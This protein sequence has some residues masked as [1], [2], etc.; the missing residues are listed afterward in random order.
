MQLNSVALGRSHRR[1]GPS[2]MW[3][4]WETLFVCLR[5]P[6]LIYIAR[7]ET[8]GGWVMG[9]KVLHHPNNKRVL[10]F[11]FTVY[12][13][14]MYAK[15]VS[16]FFVML[17]IWRGRQWVHNNAHY[18]LSFHASLTPRAHKL[19]TRGENHV[20]T[21]LLDWIDPMHQLRLPKTIVT[22]ILLTN[23][24]TCCLVSSCLPKAY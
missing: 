6:R 3:I 23:N 8:A 20:L 1:N 11:Y 7:V 4:K 24:K 14:F 18:P 9:F 17:F 22:Q 13:I 15:K 10:R 12:W 21:W 2:A 19:Q 16:E 5:R